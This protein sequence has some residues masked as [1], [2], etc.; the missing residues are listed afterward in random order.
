VLPTTARCSG[1]GFMESRRALRKPSGILV[2]AVALP[3]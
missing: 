1:A 2:L 3:W